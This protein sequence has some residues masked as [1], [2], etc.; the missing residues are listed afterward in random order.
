MR[1]E[2]GACGSRGRND[3]AVAGSHGHGLQRSGRV[4]ESVHVAQQGRQPAVDLV[5]HAFLRLDLL[6]LGLPVLLRGTGRRN[7]LLH[8]RGNVNALA[9]KKRRRTDCELGHAVASCGLPAGTR[10]PGLSPAPGFHGRTIVIGKNLVG[11]YCPTSIRRL[12]WFYCNS[13]RT[14]CCI[15]LDC[16]RAAIPVCCR[17]LNFVMLATALGMSAAMMLS[18][19]CDRF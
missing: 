2:R 13:L 18:S 8:G 9:G 10:A 5:Y 14:A 6:L 17:M 1:S 3:V 16:D 19:D 12:L 7:E 11:R 15:W 4:F